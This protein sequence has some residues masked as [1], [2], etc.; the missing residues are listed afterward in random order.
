MIFIVLNEVSFYNTNGDEIKLS[1]LVNQIIN[2]YALKREVGETELTDFNEGSE[3]RNLIEAFA[4]LEYA[5][6]E[7]EHENTRI[8]FISTSYGTW[9]DKIGELPFIDLPRDEG[10]VAGGT[11][12][13]TLA[14]VQ[15]SDFVIPAGTIVTAPDSELDF[16]TLV[17]ATIY[18][19]E[20]SV[21]T[22]VECL[23]AG[24][25]GNVKK[26]K[27]TKIDS[28]NAFDPEFIS[29]SNP[30]AMWGGSDYETDDDYRDRLL[31]NVQSDG[32]GSVGYYISLCEDVEG[33][34]D[35]KLVNY[36]KS[37]ATDPDYT[38]KVLVN[39]YVKPV[40][41]DVLIDVLAQLTVIDNHVLNHSFIVDSPEYTSVDLVIELDVTTEM[42]ETV[43]SDCLT[44]FFDG[45]G[46]DRSDF[47]GLRIGESLSRDT[48]IGVL[49]IFPEVVGVTSVKSDSV[50]VTE[51]TPGVNGV[52]KLNSV[53]FNQNVV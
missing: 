19:G 52:L 23:T 53:D 30:E 5:R 35:V 41:N 36:V 16:T 21:E 25:D 27:I 18:E 7:E 13:F 38:R 22:A 26:E 29:V 8:A 31:A 24:S 34:H 20:L 51:L 11:V 12:I 6:L 14:A 17:D 3:I 10:S 46:F 48:I 49:N 39:G 37:T 47:T 42:D 28:I 43:L 4:V 45:T 2:F 15:D 40:P 33:V 44:A 50:E 1:N 32:F 9:L